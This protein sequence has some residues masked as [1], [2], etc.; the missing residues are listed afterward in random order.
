MLCG[1]LKGTVEP[2][3]LA[4]NALVGVPLTLLA[5]WPDVKS[6]EMPYRKLMEVVLFDT[7]TNGIKISKTAT[8]L[9]AS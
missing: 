4:I 3:T 8:L 7:S 1:T 9:A 2:V 6:S 5:K